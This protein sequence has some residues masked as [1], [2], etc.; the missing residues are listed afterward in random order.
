MGAE[1][2]LVFN[3]S[4]REKD[5]EKNLFSILFYVRH[6]DLTDK[7][8]TSKITGILESKDDFLKRNL[9]LGIK[10]GIPINLP[11]SSN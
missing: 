4:G 3:I 10:V 9:S 1:G 11:Q 5:K 7:R 2:G 8:R 6:E